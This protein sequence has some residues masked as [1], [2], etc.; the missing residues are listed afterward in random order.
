MSVSESL[1]D[2]RRVVRAAAEV[3]WRAYAEEWK[4]RRDVLQALRPGLPMVQWFFTKACNFRCSYCNVPGSAKDDLSLEERLDGLDTIAE[5]FHPKVLSISGG[6]PTIKYQELGPFIERARRHGM[7]VGMNTNGTNLD[8]ERIR[9]LRDSGLLYLSFS[10][11]GVPPKDDDSVFEKATYAS[12]VGI[13]SAIQPVLSTA[14]WHL[15][16]EL[17]ERTHNACALLN[18][19]IV[20]DIGGEYSSTNLHA[21]PVDEVRAFYAA[22]LRENMF[23]VKPFPRFLKFMSESY[24]DGWLCSKFNWLTVDHD[25]TLKHCNEFSSEF[26]IADLKDPER[27]KAFQEYRQKSR[28]SCSGCYYECYHTSDAGTLGILGS[29]EYFKLESLGRRALIYRK[30]GILL[31]AVEKYYPPR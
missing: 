6:E 2:G 15:R 14:N 20:N 9:G 4:L 8:N 3:T 29:T 17:M 5:L 19:S 18:P 21:P 25:G 11:D 22:L 12:C 13:L 16:H 30:L 10:H 7:I 24:G 27:R 28:D 23:N 31:E 1:R 26:T